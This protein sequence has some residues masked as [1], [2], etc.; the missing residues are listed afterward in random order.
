M[1]THD[2]MSS[3][4]HC[5]SFLTLFVLFVIA[6]EMNEKS[7]IN[8]AEGIFMIYAL[9]FV[10]EKLAAMQE[11]GIRVYSAN[12]SRYTSLAR[13]HLTPS[14]LWNGFDIA[15]ITVYISYASLR[16]YGINQDEAWA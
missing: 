16:L 11:H 15:F 7:T 4:K 8:T 5:F 3:F 12:V 10:V 14:Q 13:L 6:L 1:S 2:H 9:G